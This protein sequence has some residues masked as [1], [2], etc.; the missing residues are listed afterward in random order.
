LAD[1][2]AT[3]TAATVSFAAAPAAVVAR[4]APLMLL[5]AVEATSC[6]DMAGAFGRIVKTNLLAF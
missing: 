5:P 6:M 3:V 1:P 4:L 2:F